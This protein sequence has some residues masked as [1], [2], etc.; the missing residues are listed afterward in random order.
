MG[1]KYVAMSF[2]SLNLLFVIGPVRFAEKI[3][4]NTI[5]ADLL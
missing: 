5:P 3:S 4:R 2:H 1:P